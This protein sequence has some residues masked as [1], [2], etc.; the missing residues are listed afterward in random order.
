MRVGMSWTG[1]RWRRQTMTPHE[2]EVVHGWFPCAEPGC[3][4]TCGPFVAFTVGATDRR[5]WCV[6]HAD[7]ARGEECHR[8]GGDVVDGD[9]VEETDDDSA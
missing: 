3:K 5:V 1:K 9:V 4:R 8:E 7:C 6:D 2:F